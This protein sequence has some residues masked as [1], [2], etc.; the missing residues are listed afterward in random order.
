MKLKGIG[1]D[2]LPYIVESDKNSTNP[3]VFWMKPKTVGLVQRRV[4][5]PD[6]LELPNGGESLFEQR[7]LEFLAG[8]EKV[9]NFQFSKDNPKLADLGIIKKVSDIKFLTILLLELEGVVVE[10]IMDEVD[11]WSFLSPSQRKKIELMT[12]FALTKNEDMSLQERVSYNCDTCQL[13]KKHEERH[14]Y[15]LNDR[16][17]LKMPVIKDQDEFTGDA[18]FYPDT[19]EKILTSDEFLEDFWELTV[20]AQAYSGIPAYIALQR[21]YSFLGWE[22]EVCV[23]GLVDEEYIKILE[24]AIDCKNM[25]ALPYPGGYFDQPNQLIEAFQAVQSTLAEY[26]RI[27]MENATRKGKGK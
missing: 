10:E 20:R 5:Y 17:Q 2:A 6:L 26:E 24:W 3:T 25:A 19:E 7:Q 21:F 18:N 27:K 8:C 23:T 11:S 9:E 12:Y 1:I 15:F 14:C 4:S 13:M 22:K 16:L